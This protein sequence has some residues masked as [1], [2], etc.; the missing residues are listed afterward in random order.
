MIENIIESILCLI[1]FFWGLIVILRI[2]MCK[3]NI[4]DYFY[5]A[6]NNKIYMKSSM[7]SKKKWK[8]LKREENKERIFDGF[9]KLA[10]NKI[11]KLITHKAMIYRLMAC[12]ELGYITIIQIKKHVFRKNIGKLEKQLGAKKVNKKLKNVYFV[13]IKT[14]KNIK[15]Y[16]ID[17]LKK[18]YYK[19]CRKKL[20]I[21]EP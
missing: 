21:K 8:S 17:E 5:C 16:N 4:N 10:E 2:K 1:I 11:Y 7:I 20:E 18:V 14:T 15:N 12:E 13:K 6:L 3:I 9:D 19:I